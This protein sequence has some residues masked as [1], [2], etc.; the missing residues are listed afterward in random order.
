MTVGWTI[1][2]CL[3]E[4]P[5]YAVQLR[6]MLEAVLQVRLLRTPR[7]ELVE[8]QEIVWQRLIESE[9][10]IVPLRGVRGHRGYRLLGQLIA[11]VFLLILLVGAAWFVLSRVVLPPD[12]RNV[13][14]IETLTPTATLTATPAVTVTSSAAVMPTTTLT[15]TATP[16][17]TATTTPTVTGTQSPSP[18]ASPTTTVIGVDSDCGEP[19][20]SQDAVNAV[21]AIYPNTTVASVRETT[22][23][24]GTQ[25][26]E[27]KTSH[28]IT[29]NIDVACG[30]I[31]SIDRSGTNGP[32]T[33]TTG[34][35]GSTDADNGISGSGSDI[36]SNSNDNENENEGD[37]SGS[38]MGD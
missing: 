9:P 33:P 29:V 24:G 31:L 25:V 34:G 13:P 32:N 6:P 38:G 36:E 23:F 3:A 5:D 28:N 1:D 21:L 22:K 19:R 30:I 18:S 27:V 17:L 4:Y 26:W 7:W 8:D 16:S 15:L 2:E 35:S 37:S 10:Y 11:A 14:I 12:N 20:T